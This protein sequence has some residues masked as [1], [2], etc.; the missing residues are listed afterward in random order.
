MYEFVK[1]KTHQLITNTTHHKPNCKPSLIDLIITKYPDVIS[2]IKHN[3]PIG[4]SHH[5]SITAVLNTDFEEKH[6]SNKEKVLK[7]NFD[8]ADFN[9]INDFLIKVDWDVLIKDK[10]VD[11]A[12]CAI[13]DHIQTAQK[14]F[15]PNKFISSE[16]RRPTAVNK[17]ATLHCLL[18]SKR[19]FFKLHKK[20]KTKLSLRDYN[21]ARNRVSFKVKQLKKEK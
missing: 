5:D 3:P 10:S 19:H 11:E 21:D 8:K 18:Q 2:N 13:K 14:N 1:I 15:I 9:A 12:W 4:K 17:D 6:K 16:K 20:Y 7:P